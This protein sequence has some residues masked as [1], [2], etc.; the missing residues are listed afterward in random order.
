MQSWMCRRDGARP[1][2]VRAECAPACH[3]GDQSATCGQLQQLSHST[4]RAGRSIGLRLGHHHPQSLHGTHTTN[5]LVLQKKDECNDHIDG[6]IQ[7]LGIC[8]VTF[9]IGL[10][11]MP[12]PLICSKGWPECWSMEA[13]GAGGIHHRRGGHRSH[14]VCNWPRLHHRVSAGCNHGDW[15]HPDRGESEPHCN[16]HCVTLPCYILAFNARGQLEQGLRSGFA[17]AIAEPCSATFWLVWQEGN[18]SKGSDLE[19]R[20]PL[21]N[22]ALPHSGWYGKRAT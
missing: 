20:W 22:P 12:C 3:C 8:E 5:H 1:C 9:A 11:Q 21:Q 15:R 18:L 14:R 7:S 10:S 13:C 4:V 6:M 2:T 17:K 19:L 16:G